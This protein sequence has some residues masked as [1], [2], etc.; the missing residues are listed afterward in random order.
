MH[1][2]TNRLRYDV[3]CLIS[4][5]KHIETFQLLRKPQLEQHGLELL[6]VVDIILEVE[7]KYGVEITDDLPV[8]TIH[9][10][11]HIIEVQSLRQAS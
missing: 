2:Y 8:F 6:D 11:A 3:A 1:S 10:F 9:D 5:L 4:D 7:K